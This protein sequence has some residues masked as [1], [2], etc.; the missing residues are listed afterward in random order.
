MVTSDSM[1]DF[2]SYAYQENVRI[3]LQN[4]TINNNSFSWSKNDIRYST[5]LQQPSAVHAEF[6]DLVLNNVKIIN[7]NVTGLLCYRTV[8]LVNSNSTSV[9]HNNTGID[10]GGLAMYSDSYIFV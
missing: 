6:V 8:V 2:S 9:F 10:G 7:N 5:S 1:L 3:V 4:V